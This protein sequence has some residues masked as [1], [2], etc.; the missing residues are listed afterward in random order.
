MDTHGLTSLFKKL[1]LIKAFGFVLIVGGFLFFIVK[2]FVML[3]DFSS[4]FSTFFI[5]AG[6]VF[7]GVFIANYAS[8]RIK[9]GISSKIAETVLGK[10]F[11][12]LHYDHL[13][14]FSDNEIDNVEMGFPAY[15]RI[16]TNDY[17]EAT[18]RGLKIALCDLTLTDRRSDSDG[19]SHDVTVFSGAYLKIP[20]DKYFETPVTVN[21]RGG[22]FFNK[23]IKLEDESFNAEYGIFSDSDHSAFYVLTPHMMEKIKR[24]DHLADAEIFLNFDGQGY[25]YLAIN[26][27]TDA[28]EMHFTNS[29]VDEAIGEFQ[30]QVAYLLAIIDEIIN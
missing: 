19:K 28:F 14:G 5:S 21:K 26:N 4:P 25:L 11:D 7:A 24:I 9:E 18:Y 12:N 16:K 30:E 27:Y 15:D 8:K 1:R 3:H 10:Y 23:G 20:F 13:G 17:I 6:M 29:D 2:G 22:K